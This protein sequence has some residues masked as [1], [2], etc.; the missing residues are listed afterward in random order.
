MLVIF[1]LNEPFVVERQ[2]NE[3]IKEVLLNKAGIN[4]SSFSIF[5]TNIDVAEVTTSW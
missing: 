2:S 4:S 3:N 5:N 1:F